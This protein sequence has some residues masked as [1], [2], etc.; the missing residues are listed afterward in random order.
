M[1]RLLFNNVLSGL[2]R[3][4]SVSQDSTFSVAEANLFAVTIQFLADNSDRAV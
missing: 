4:S 3:V 1:E 2:T